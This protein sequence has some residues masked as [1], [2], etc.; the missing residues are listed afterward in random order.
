MSVIVSTSL[1]L[2]E[3]RQQYGESTPRRQFLFARLQT[4]VRLLLESGQLR[5]LYLFGSFTTAKPTPGD[6]DCLVVMA[7]GFTTTT[8]TSPHLEVFQ[9]DTCRLLYQT[10]IFWVTEAIPQ[11]HISAMLDVFSRNRDGAL[12]PIIEVTL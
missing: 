4:V 6:L 12:Q 10:D 1:T 8:L 11:E 2:E 5:R 3:V 9:H 7:T